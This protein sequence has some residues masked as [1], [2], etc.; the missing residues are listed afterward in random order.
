MRRR[1]NRARL[2]AE[3]GI[4]SSIGRFRMPA[5]FANRKT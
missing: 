5:R 4:R 3:H 1:R 2:N